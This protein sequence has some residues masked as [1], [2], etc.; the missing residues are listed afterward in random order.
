MTV[1]MKAVKECARKTEVSIFVGKF[2]R[3]RHLITRETD[4]EQSIRIG[5]C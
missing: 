2:V 5:S 4:R 1:S 3:G